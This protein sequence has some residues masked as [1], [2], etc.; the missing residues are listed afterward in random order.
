MRKCIA[1]WWIPR[2]WIPDETSTIGSKKLK[3]GTGIWSEEKEVYFHAWGLDVED[4]AS[5]SVAIVEDSNGICYTTPVS[6][7]RFLE[8]IK[9]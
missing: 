8:P 9:S 2:E 3:E 1:K 6:N 7:V 4:N 5:Y